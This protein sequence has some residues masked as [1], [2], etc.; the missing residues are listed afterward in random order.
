[1]PGEAG[2]MGLDGQQV[3]I[4]K[5]KK[6]NLKVDSQTVLVL[7]GKFRPVEVNV[8]KILGNDFGL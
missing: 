4:A 5:Q 3:S 6:K 1:M 8:S 7:G 2:P